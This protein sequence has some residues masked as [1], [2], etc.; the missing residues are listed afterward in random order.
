MKYVIL[1]SVFAAACALRAAQPVWNGLEPEKRLAGATV[2]ASDTRGKITIVYRFTATDKEQLTLLKKIDSAYRSF[3]QQSVLMIASC[4][5]EGQDEQLKTLLAKLALSIPVYLRADV[6]DASNAGTPHFYM[7]DHRGKTRNLGSDYNEVME[8]VST[9]M[10]EMIVSAD[11]LEGSVALQQYK[12]M[13][14]KIK[15]GVNLEDKALTNQFANA[16][17]V[18]EKALSK[19][20]KKKPQQQPRPQNGK[21]AK[22][23]QEEKMKMKAEE[24]QQILD[25]IAK[26]KEDILQRLPEEIELGGGEAYRDLT[27]LIKSFPS[28][29]AKYEPE[30]KRISKDPKAVKAGQALMKPL[31]KKMTPVK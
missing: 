29:K 21:K 11:F 20:A 3:A 14:G 4:R 8:S 1:F 15:Y 7:V 12:G 27:W 23:T 9:A 25:A 31:S 6:S 17:K 10:G 28:E 24:A 26:A 13:K 16:I 19:P 30:L 22:P 18:Y 5:D 2:S